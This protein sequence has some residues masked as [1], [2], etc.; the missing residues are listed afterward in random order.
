[1]TTAILSRSIL[2]QSLCI[3]LV[4]SSACTGE[5]RDAAE[6]PPAD[7]HEVSVQTVSRVQPAQPTA[8]FDAYVAATVNPETFDAYVQQH[9]EV[10]QA[11]F[12][13]CFNRVKL[14]LALK[15]QEVTR[16]CDALTAITD[17]VT[18]KSNDLS[19]IDRILDGIG[20]AAQGAQSFPTTT[21]GS[22]LV[23]GKKMLGNKWEPLNRAWLGVLR[24]PLACAQ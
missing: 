23:L 22:V 19:K 20:K 18:C 14:A 2:M 7:N 8:L 10:Q 3:G 12:F 11:A 24:Q 9:P 15:W 5:K 13:D 16:S 6:N 17:R 21:G 4:I 1:M